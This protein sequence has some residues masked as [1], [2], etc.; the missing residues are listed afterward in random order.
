M[1]HRTAL[2]WLSVFSILLLLLMHPVLI[3]PVRAADPAVR[4]AVQPA[5]QPDGAPGSASRPLT[6]VTTHFPPYVIAP[7]TA[8]SGDPLPVEGLAT[9]IVREACHRAGLV[10]TISAL[11]WA[12]AYE[13][14][15]T[16]PGT[17]IFAMAR[18][19]EREQLFSWLGTVS[20]Y[21]VK[22]YRLTR[23]TDI[24]VVDNPM[25]L[26]SWRI[27]GQSRDIKAQWLA[28]HGFP[29]EWAASAETTVRMLFG[30]RVDLVAGDSLSFPIRVTAL[31]Y[32]PD[33]LTAVATLSD[34]STP[35]YLAAHPDTDPDCQE[36][37]RLALSSLHR[38]GTWNRLWE[39]RY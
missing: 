27:A 6:V 26:Q 16:Q 28:D 17:L 34:I 39:N 15:H 23:R 13:Q 8:G 2:S 4:P 18:T 3:Y 37:I 25:Q 32:S 10:C 35:L 9:T 7:V 29:V 5:T 38:D 33:Q 31:G 21:Q 20:P 24:P 11:P 22:L 14:A 30:G 19:P 36:K 1:N 12:R